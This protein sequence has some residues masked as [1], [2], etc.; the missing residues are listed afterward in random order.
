M[1]GII[2]SIPPLVEQPPGN[3]ASNP[4][5]LPGVTYTAAIPTLANSWSGLQ[6]FL[7]GSVQFAGSTSGNTFLNASAIASGTLTL[8]AATDTLVGRNTTDTLTNKTL[9]SPTI[10]GAT[11]SNPTLAGATITGATITT[12]TYNGNTWTAGT[13]TLTIAAAKTLTANNTLTL[14]GTDGTTQT[15]QASDT[16]V[17]RATTDTLTNKTISGATNTLSNIANASLTNSSMTLAGH[18]VSL[19]GTQTFAASDLT[20]GT[21]GSGS[22]VLATSPTLVTPAL[23]AATATTLNGNTFTTGT[24]TLTGAAAKTL[25]FNNSLTLAGTDG[26]TQTFPSTS[27]TVVSSVT[28]AGGDLTG[29]YPSPTIAANAVTNAKMATMA[30]YTIKANAT[31]SS[32]VP[33]DVSIPALTQKASP[34]ATDK[35]M[36]ADSAASDAL[37]YATVSSLAS[38]GSVSSIAGNTGA[39]TLS[40]GIKNSTNDIQA[41]PVFHRSYLAGLTLSTA[42]SSATF[43]IAAGIAVDSTNAGFMSLASAYTKTTSAWAVGT[44]TGAL[45]TGSIAA[46]TWYHVYLI[47]RTDT[48]VVDVLIS[49]SASSPTMPTNYTLSRRIGAMKTNGSSQWTKFVQLGDEFL[50]DTPVGDVNTTFGTTSTLYTLSVPTGLQLWALCRIAASNGATSAADLFQSTDESTQAVSTPSGNMTL[51]QATAAN[52]A[53]AAHSIRTNTSAQI[54]GVSSSASTTLQIVTYGWIDRRGRDN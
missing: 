15:F 17:G 36:I 45:D 20:N 24:Y 49:T 32:A 12:S 53:A 10:N 42:G 33:T 29:T 28:F 18:V 30:A 16:I 6:T 23:G 48:G 39:F 31:G 43:G 21:T 35:I 34:A 19:G 13:G 22:V 37:K 26:T 2:T 27:G 3:N 40:N 5:G 41:D 4:A 7:N 47:K 50:W 14:A 38:A 9:T 46:S 54:R 1:T 51:A 52:F 11:I 44:A 25:T 8:P